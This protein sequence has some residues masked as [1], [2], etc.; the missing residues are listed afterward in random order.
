MFMRYISHEIRTPLN[1]VIMGMDVLREGLVSDRATE[2]R[3]ETLADMRFSCEASISIL[4][5]IL[6]SDK[7]ESS[8]LQLEKRNINA[9]KLVHSTVKPF[10]LQVCDHSILH[11]SRNIRAR[12]VK[13][14][15]SSMWSVLIATCSADNIHR[16]YR[17]E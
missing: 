9:V 2:E 16:R 12:G 15:Y 11:V 8:T 7:L 14:R 13:C 5:N 1:T 3:I 4:N 17:R 6:T 10:M